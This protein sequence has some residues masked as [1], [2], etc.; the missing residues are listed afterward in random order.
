[1]STPCMQLFK[2]ALQ[3]SSQAQTVVTVINRCI[4]MWGRTY[5]RR[6]RDARRAAARQGNMAAAVTTAGA[7]QASV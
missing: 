2:L 3:I 4:V 7:S 6:A 1:M 5:A